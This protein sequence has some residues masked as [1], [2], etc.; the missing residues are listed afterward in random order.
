MLLRK[1]GLL[2]WLVKN[3]GYP[4]HPIGQRK[5]E[6]NLKSCTAWLILLR[7]DLPRGSQIHGPRAWLD[8]RAGCGVSRWQRRKEERKRA[9]GLGGSFHGLEASSTF[10]ELL[11]LELSEACET[12]QAACMIFSQDHEQSRA[13]KGPGHRQ[14]QW[15]EKEMSEFRVVWG[16]F[17]GRIYL[18]NPCRHFHALL[19]SLKE[20]A[21]RKQRLA[22]RSVQASKAG[23]N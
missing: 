5:N 9:C 23:E 11:R 3:T 20:G 17:L 10:A 8:P 16:K 18:A 14:V 2:N 12:Q 15:W 4:K 22:V 7:Q 1:N 21:P 13:A 6:Q 19:R